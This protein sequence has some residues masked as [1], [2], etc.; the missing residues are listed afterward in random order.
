MSPAIRPILAV[1]VAGDVPRQA[2]RVDAQDRRLERRQAL[3]EQGGD[4]ARQHVA[5]AAGRH[6]GVAAIVQVD[7]MAVGDDRLGPF[8]GHDQMFAARRISDGHPL[9]IGLD[10]RHSLDDQSAELG[11]VRRD[12]GRSLQ[13]RGPVGR[14]REGIQR[15]GVE[16]D[17]EGQVVQDPGDQGRNLVTLAES[18]ADGQDGRPFQQLFQGLAGGGESDQAV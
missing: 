14:L 3:A 16:H 7:A 4:D 8:E 6:A 13:A 11:G 10:F 17:G 12:D 9:A 2:V 18:R 5:R 15:V 1:L